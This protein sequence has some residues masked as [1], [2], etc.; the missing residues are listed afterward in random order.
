[1][2]DDFNEFDSL[3]EET[4]ND[5]GFTSDD[6]EDTSEEV[7]NK[8]IKRSSIIL[9]IVGIIV[10]GL[11]LLSVRIQKSISSK[12][13]VN[14]QPSIQSNKDN[15]NTSN[16]SNVTTNNWIEFN[17]SNDISFESGLI[18]TEFEVTD[19]KHYVLKASDN[20]ISLKTILKGSLKGYTGE[21]E[22]EIP[23]SKGSK[24]KVGNS[25]SVSIEIGSYN[26]KVVIGDIRY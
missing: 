15:S 21:Y 13:K 26:N 17:G 16:S 5:W 9:I 14:N 19:I 7:D 10:I 18:P 12:P 3:D 2:R 11:V 25:F 24:L 1:M 6:V 22:L 4:D 23:Y 20:N 8:G